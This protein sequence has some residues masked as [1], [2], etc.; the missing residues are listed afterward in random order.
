MD[1]G[2][3]APAEIGVHFL[4]DKPLFRSSTAMTPAAQVRMGVAG[5]KV[6]TPGT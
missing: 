6:F 1:S 2:S 3:S 4:M 5:L